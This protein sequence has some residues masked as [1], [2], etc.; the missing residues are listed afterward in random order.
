MQVAPIPGMR[1][2]PAIKRPQNDPVL[3]AV[4][5][6]ESLFG[7]KQDALSQSGGKM[8]GGQDGESTEQEEAPESVEETD[9]GPTV[10][11]FA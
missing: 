3:S 8:P 1:L 10:N 2:M 7:V 4:I 9:P 5:D 6:A 11:F